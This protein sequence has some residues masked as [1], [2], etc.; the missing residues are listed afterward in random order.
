MLPVLEI[1]HV[2]LQWVYTVARGHKGHIEYK[3][4]LPPKPLGLI[5]QQS[6]VT[7]LVGVIATDQQEEVRLLLHSEAGGTMGRAQAIHLDIS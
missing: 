5:C 4:R 2:G 7:V 6:G 1:E 3:L